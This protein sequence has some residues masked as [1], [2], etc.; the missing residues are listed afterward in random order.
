MDGLDRR[1][2]R[3]GA[4]PN[5]P[6]EAQ[7]CCLLPTGAAVDEERSEVRGLLRYLDEDE[8]AIAKGRDIDS[9]A[10]RRRMD[11]LRHHVPI[12]PLIDRARD[13]A[14]ELHD[15]LATSRAPLGHSAEDK[16]PASGVRH[17]GDVL[18]E[19]E[20]LGDFVKPVGHALCCEPLSFVLAQQDLGSAGS[21]QGGNV[22]RVE[23]TGKDR[24]NDRACSFA[25]LNQLTDRLASPRKPRRERSSGPRA[26]D[27][28]LDVARGSIESGCG[29]FDCSLDL[30]LRRP[31]RRFDLALH[32]QLAAGPDKPD[33][34]IGGEQIDAEVF[35]Q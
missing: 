15:L 34:P 4:R 10:D 5:R 8:L 28:P 25:D 13:T 31:R 18:T 1:G 9:H 21:N 7:S 3:V 23:V 29:S 14:I 17:R 11:D 30:L 22:A 2:G 19:F 32:H 16:E 26:S 24:S 12:F 33:R 6:R 35:W 27:V 20:L